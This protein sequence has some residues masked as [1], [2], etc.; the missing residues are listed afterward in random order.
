MNTRDTRDDLFAWSTRTD[1]VRLRSDTNL[2]T[3]HIIA[4]CGASRMSS[5]TVVIARL[6]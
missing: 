3:H 4:N 5:V 2:I 1:P 6:L